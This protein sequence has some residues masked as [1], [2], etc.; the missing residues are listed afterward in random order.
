M[1][2]VMDVDMITPGCSWSSPPVAGRRWSVVRG[3]RVAWPIW[4]A[5]LAAWAAS[6]RT[7]TPP[8]KYKMTWR[9]STPPAVISAVGT[10]PQRGCGHGHIGGPRLRRGQL[11][12]PPPQPA[13]V[14]VGG[15]GCLPQDRVKVLLLLGAHRGS[16][17]GRGWLGSA[18]RRTRPCQ[19]KWSAGG[20]TVSL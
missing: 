11:R 13:D 10:P 20:A 6:P 5:R 16:P 18:P 4:A 1:S 2:S 7:Y 17:F 15:E 19:L 8:W 12:E 3:T 9:G 14:S